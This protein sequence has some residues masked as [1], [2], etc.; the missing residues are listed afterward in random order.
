[1]LIVWLQCHRLAERGGQVQEGPSS[2]EPQD[3]RGWRRWELPVQI[4][5]S[6]GIWRRGLTQNDPPEVHGLHLAWERL[7]QRLHHWRWNLERGIVCCQKEIECNLGRRY[8]DL[9]PLWD[10]QP[11]YWNLCLFKLTNAHLP[12]AGRV[13]RTLQIELSWLQPLQLN[14]CDELELWKSFHQAG[15]REI[16]GWCSQAKLAEDRADASCRNN[17]RICNRCSKTCSLRCP[18]HQTDGPNDSEVKRRVSD[19][20][21]PEGC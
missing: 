15:P 18:K 19:S 7:L 3:N 2:Q 10:L 4:N 6:S 11:P 16:W 21:S 14:N 13:A 8:W 17:S 12:R 5:C 1:M 20:A 9:S